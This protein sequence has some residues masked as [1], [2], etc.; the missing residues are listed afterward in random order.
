MLWRDMLWRDSQMQPECDWAGECD[1]TGK[2]T[3]M[4]FVTAA[5]VTTLTTAVTAT[6]AAD[7]HLRG[8]AVGVRGAPGPGLPAGTLRR[9]RVGHAVA[10]G[11][12]PR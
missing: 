6:T 10:P 2:C 5:A 12:G 7:C 8:G 4:V 3:I 11:H 9:G 1:W